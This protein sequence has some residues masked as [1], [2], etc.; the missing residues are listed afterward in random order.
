MAQIF[1]VKRRLLLT[2]ISACLVIVF[3]ELAARCIA[4]LPYLARTK[5]MIP[6]HELGWKTVANAQL[7]D[8]FD[9]YGKV[10]YSTSKYGFRVFGDISSKKPKVFVIG[11]SQ[12]Q[13]RKV[14]DGKTYYEVLGKIADCEIF[15]YGA[16]GYGTLQ[17]Y[18]VLEKY[19]E[20]IQPDLILWQFSRN[21]IHN[22]S[23]ILESSG[24]ASS[25]HMMRPYLED[26]R[27]VL[28][29]PH[30][31]W[32]YRNFWRHSYLIK[33]FHIKLGLLLSTNKGRI[34]NR[35]FSLE[36]PDF[37]E[38]VMTTREV[39]SMA[40]DR[41]NPVP[42]V[43]FCSSRFPNSV[44]AKAIKRLCSAAEIPFIDGVAEAIGEA[45]SK[46]IAVNGLPYDAH[47]NDTAHQIAGRL[48][49]AYLIDNK[50]MALT[51]DH[52]DGRSKE[53]TKWLP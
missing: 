10:K 8:R 14:T 52:V 48:L 51:K 34:P 26:N 18:L 17:E 11:D 30:R 7:E 25:N 22:N 15:A 47:W 2:L 49:A 43:A 19:L 31:S 40:R 53:T 38:A 42:L 9:V 16:G 20:D 37:L 1:S 36:N 32:V 21:D 28:R 41:A 3:L 24:F 29:Y 45:E 39:I 13:A 12:T 5:D 35:I 6:C 44:Q 46:G 33:M 50:L 4:W 23:W 27:V